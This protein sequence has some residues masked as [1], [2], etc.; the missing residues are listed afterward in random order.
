MLKIVITNFQYFCS[1]NLEELNT[2]WKLVSIED[3]ESFEKFDSYDIFGI[4]IDS[5]VN[6]AK[7][8]YD[9]MV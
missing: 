6:R 3:L 5:K 2:F 4:E 9:V 7:F 8:V 1:K